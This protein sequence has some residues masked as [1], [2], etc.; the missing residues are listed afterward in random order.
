MPRKMLPPPMTIATSTPA[1]AALGD[2][3]GDGVEEFGLDAEGLVPGKHL[4]RN[5]EQDA[6]VGGLGHSVALR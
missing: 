2:L 5:L 3:G 6:L 4:A 1:F